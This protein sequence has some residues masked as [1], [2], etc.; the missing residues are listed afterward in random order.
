[1]TQNSDAGQRNLPLLITMG[2]VA[3]VVLVS[4]IV[5]FTRGAATQLD[6][7]SPEGVTQRFAQAVLD[8]DL[9]AARALLTP[10]LAK[11]CTPEI[12]QADRG[13]SVSLLRSEISG[14]EATVY[15][16]IVIPSGSGLFGPN[17]YV[18]RVTFG[19][20]KTDGVWGISDAPWQF[21]ICEEMWK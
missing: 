14:D 11:T 10:E 6:P 17:D 3:L 5:I 18:N 9:V 8:D 4:L 15:A 13:V 16:E 20:E 21:V 12:A 2:A 7:A 19:L 1:M